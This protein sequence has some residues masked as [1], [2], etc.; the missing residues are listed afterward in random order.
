MAVDKL[1]DSTQLNADLTSVANAIRTKGGTNASLAF[2]A[3][4]VSAVEAIPSGGGGITLAPMDYPV[5]I[6]NGRTT[7]VLLNRIA[8][9]STTTLLASQATVTTGSTVTYGDMATDGSHIWFRASNCTTCTYNGVQAD[10][11]VSSSCFQVTI[12]NG[13]D[14]T[15]P[16]VVS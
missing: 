11:V 3:G 15:I 4:F 1:V 16:F 8:Y 13:F 7:S 6:K 12:P 9:D 14:G 10:F 2:P 5:L